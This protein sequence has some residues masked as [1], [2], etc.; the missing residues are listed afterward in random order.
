M[1]NNRNSEVIESKLVITNA[2]SDHNSGR[3]SCF[4]NILLANENKRVITLN[5]TLVD[6]KILNKNELDSMDP[7]ARTIKLNQKVYCPE[8]ITPTY[9]GTYRYVA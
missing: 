2:Q 8:L 9:R 5:T 7:A 6:I 1:F 4:A 3:Y